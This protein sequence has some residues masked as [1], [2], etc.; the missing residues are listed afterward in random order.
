MCQTLV[1]VLTRNLTT[2]D[3]LFHSTSKESVLHSLNE[4][5]SD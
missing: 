3:S 4:E 1:L 5:L 2:A